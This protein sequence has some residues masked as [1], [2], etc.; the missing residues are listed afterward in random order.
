MD[1]LWRCGGLRWSQEAP[2][3]RWWHPRGGERKGG[4]LA[5]GDTVALA[6]PQ[7]AVRGCAGVSRSG[8][9]M[10]CPGEVVI[11]PEARRDQCEACAAL[12]RSQ[13]VAADTVPDDPRP[14]AV[15]LAWFAP[16]LTKVGI[17]A[18][19]R[20]RR[21][22]LE[23]AAVCFTFLGHGPLM[24]ARR[25]EAALG[26]GLGI[27]DRVLSG[28]KRAARSSLPG[29]ADRLRELRAV[30]D[31]AAGVRGWRDTLTPAPFEPV[32]HAA[33][34]G[35]EPTAPRPGARITALTPGCAVTGELRAV[36]GG[37]LYLATP[38]GEL[39]LDSRLANAWPLTRPGPHSHFPPTAPVAREQAAP[40]GLF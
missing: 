27:P 9:R 5:L 24:S 3:W 21:R 4:R 28:R 12:D 40:E 36:A 2:R 19:E 34:F 8:R 26:A 7:G 17:T 22:L 16:G 1:D 23:Q 31:A 18:A 15:Y 33:V 20:G 30:Y 39:L 32:D 38:E 35:L 37:D 6:V 10:P 29:K 11:P 14:Y 13:S 25:A